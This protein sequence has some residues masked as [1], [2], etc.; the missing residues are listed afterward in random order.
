MKRTL[1]VR[2]D[3]EDVEKLTSR[4]TEI[5]LTLSTLARLLIR[6]SLSGTHSPFLTPSDAT[7]SRAS[8]SQDMG[9]TKVAG[10]PLSPREAEILSKIAEGQANQRIAHTLGVSR[11]TI[12]K[13]LASIIRKLSATD[14]THA[15][16]LAIRQGHIRP[17]SE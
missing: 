10:P 3:E 9:R 13:D 4:A 7:S 5:G 16:V 8:G 15:V 14:R 17:T 6:D 12:K 2:L 11:E 1:S